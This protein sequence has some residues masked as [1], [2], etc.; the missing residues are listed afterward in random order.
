MSARNSC[1]PVSLPNGRVLCIPALLL[2]REL[3][4]WIVSITGNVHLQRRLHTFQ[5]C[6]VSIQPPPPFLLLVE[7]M[8]SLSPR[9]AHFV[10]CVVILSVIG[11]V[12]ME[13]KLVLRLTASGWFSNHLVSVLLRYHSVLQQPFLLM[14]SAYSADMIVSIFHND[15]WASGYLTALLNDMGKCL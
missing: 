15:C 2:P 4:I 12:W 11:T 8:L 5:E 14:V 6:D 3:A 9:K 7:L 1:S 10:R 13:G